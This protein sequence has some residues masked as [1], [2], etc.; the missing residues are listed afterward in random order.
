MLLHLSVCRVL[1]S[2]PGFKTKIST[3]CRTYHL[4]EACVAGIQPKI[5]SLH[6]AWHT[7]VVRV[8][9]GTQA[10]ETT[11]ETSEVSD[12]KPLDTLKDNQVTLRCN[13]GLN[14]DIC[15]V[16]NQD[17]HAFEKVPSCPMRL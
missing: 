5:G 4:T 6:T 7:L 11:H 12:L 2:A 13:H 15:L 8:Q 17:L 1:C 9:Q 10:K 16:G 3:S 14:L